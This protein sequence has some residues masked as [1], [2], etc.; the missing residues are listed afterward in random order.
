MKLY[1]IR[2]CMVNG[3]QRFRAIVVNEWSKIFQ[4]VAKLTSPLTSQRAAAVGLICFF[5][6]RKIAKSRVK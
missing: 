3:T 5:C 6:G 1:V 4:R 2:T